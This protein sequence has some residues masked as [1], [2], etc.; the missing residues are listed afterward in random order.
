[1]LLVDDTGKLQIILHRPNENIGMLGMNFTNAECKMLQN[2]I[3]SRPNVIITEEHLSEVD[4]LSIVVV[5]SHLMVV[6]RMQYLRG[7]RR[8]D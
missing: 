1:M 8:L 3:T 5:T 2:W 6:Y 7:H 4:R